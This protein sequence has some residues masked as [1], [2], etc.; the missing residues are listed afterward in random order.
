MSDKS[1]GDMLG[2]DVT[3]RCQECG[4]ATLKSHGRWICHNDTCALNLAAHRVNDLYESI[5]VGFYWFVRL[6]IMAMIVY[7]AW[8]LR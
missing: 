6:V 2:Y 1:K 3:G 7:V 4:S 8:R 5:A